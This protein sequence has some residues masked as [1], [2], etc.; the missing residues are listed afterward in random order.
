M[1]KEQTS[2]K[3]KSFGTIRK[4]NEAWTDIL[5]GIGGSPNEA[6]RNPNKG[7]AVI[8]GGRTTDEWRFCL[9]VVVFLAEIE[10]T[11][12]TCLL[13]SICYQMSHCEFRDLYGGKNG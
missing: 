11:V 6:I 4:T 5:F 3:L 10:Y 9:L 8:R 13:S 2:R 7:K 1:L 12:R